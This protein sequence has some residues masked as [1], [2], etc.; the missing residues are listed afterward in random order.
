MKPSLRLAVARFA[1]ALG[2]SLAIAACSQGTAPA[3]GPAKGAAPDAS[4]EP[5]TAQLS[6]TVTAAEPFTAA[7]VY[8]WNRDK[9][10]L[11]MV[12]T[13]K[14]RYS[15]PKLMA[16][17][18]ELWAEKGRLRS[19]HRMMRIEAGTAPVVDHALAPAPDFLLTLKD[20]DKGG[21]QF[22]SR[23]AAGAKLASYDEMYPPGPGRETAE[24]TC[25]R[26][27][28]QAFLP[29]QKYPREQWR[30]LIDAMLNAPPG[31][32]AQSVRTDSVSVA[33]REV[34]ADY[35]AKNF[36]PGSPPRILRI[37]AQYPLDEETL[38]KGMYIEYLLPLLPGLD[39]L[40]RSENEPGKNRTHRPYLDDLGYIWA[41]NGLIG[42]TRLDPRTAQFSHYPFGTDERNREVDMYGRKKGEPDSI[43]QYIFPHDITVDAE[44]NI[45]WAEFQGGHVGRLTQSTGRID[46]FPIDPEK[47]V[48]DEAGVV[49][50]A[51]GHTPRPD[52]KGNIWFTVI[53]GNKIGK[54]DKQTQ[55]IKLWE[56]PTE[57]SFPYGL[58]VTPEDKLWF[59]ELM[60]CNVTF[61]DPVTEKF[62]EHKSPSAP[63]AIN[64]LAADSKGIVWYSVFNGGKLGR[65]DPGTGEMKEYDVRW[66]TRLNVSAPYGMVVDQ[67]DKVWFGDGGLGGALVKFD[68]LTE[69]FA[70]FPTPR[71]GDN[72]GLDLTRDGALVYTMRSNNQAAI[73]MFFPDV[74]RMSGYAAFR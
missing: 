35:L 41:S 24:K 27:H 63:C 52:S 20:P 25:M 56:I 4:P 33:E 22:G 44:H 69:K 73:G 28:G 43:W 19:E 45:W 3:A 42:V 37:D 40:K 6:G 14:G 12:Y 10:V 23:P 2:A 57:H 65:L 67:Q 7:Q 38:A 72:P 47:K 29:G 60:A 32:D 66:F 31:R 64:R 21:P 51:R 26:C 58:I 16:G 1:L 5:P 48:V 46:R 54:W 53:R 18:Y 36:G 49:G 11:Y 59:V 62:T 61:F 8:A 34:L 50:N 68:P 39:P 71:Q 30:V 17:G 13:S 55:Q 9:N 74:S 70:Y 15:A